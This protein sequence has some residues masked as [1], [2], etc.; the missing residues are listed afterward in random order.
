MGEVIHFVNF[1]MAFLKKNCFLP[2]DREIGL[3]LVLNELQKID[4]VIFRWFF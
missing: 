2:I 4:S 3:K 1:N